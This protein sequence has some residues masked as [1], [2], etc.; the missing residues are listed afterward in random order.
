ME[1]LMTYGF[2]IPIQNQ[3]YLKFLFFR[4]LLLDLMV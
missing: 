3:M 4:L 1:T 2:G